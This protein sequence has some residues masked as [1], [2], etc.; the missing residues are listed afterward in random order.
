MLH[1]FP[2]FSYGWRKQI[3]AL[4]EA[5]FR[6]VVPDQRGYNLSSK[7]PLVADYHLNKLTEDV[8]AIAD[9]L[10]AAR[11]CL[12]GHDWGA[13]V[14]W[15]T[16]IQHPNRIERLAILNVPHP[17]AMLH[18]LRANLRQLG[19][20][21]YMLVFQIPGLPERMLSANNYQAATRALLQSSRPGTFS[22]EDLDRYREAWSQPGALTGMINWY[23]AIFRSRPAF[24]R[25][26]VPTRIIWGMQD[27]F[28]LPDLASESLAYCDRGDL[29]PFLN[30]T[31]WVQHEEPDRVNELL[32]DF[33]RQETE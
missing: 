16:A 12:A 1:G 5:G 4:A 11:I 21:W 14:A 23:R 27:R 15:N 6:V 28:L 30:A 20:S 3:P 26:T 29:F 2:E 22:N 31:H 7:P 10:A 19:R 8:L 17:S 32:I 18:S 9:Q 25:V 13:G 33:F 24:G